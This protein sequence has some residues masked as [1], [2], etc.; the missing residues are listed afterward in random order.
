[1]SKTEPLREYESILKIKSYLKN[2]PRD[3]AL[4]NIGLNTALRISDILSLKWGDVYDY[5]NMCYKKH[6]EITEHKTGKKVKIFLNKVVIEALM[7][8]NNYSENISDNYLFLSRKGNNR[9]I[10]R[11]RAYTIIKNASTELG[12][13]GTISCHSLRKTFGY[14]AWKKGTPPALLMDIYNH[15]SINITKR[16]LGICQ[17]DKDD[18]F[19]SITL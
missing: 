12:I 18:V 13:E 2:N 9:P 19:S 11:Q 14:H 1:M 6:I 15:S 10:T 3:F 4:I 17:D 8:L 7:Y 5:K 16:Y